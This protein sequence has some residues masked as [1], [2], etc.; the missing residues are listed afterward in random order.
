M[1]EKLRS[2]FKELSQL[3]GVSGNEQNVARYIKNALEDV[4]DEIHID[5]NEL[6]MADWYPRDNLPA[7]D[8]GISLTREMIRVFEEGR[9]PE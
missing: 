3:I 5:E 9:E 8:D 4:C 7:H 1:K 2:R 6:S